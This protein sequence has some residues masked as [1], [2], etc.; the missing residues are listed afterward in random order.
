MKMFDSGPMVL[1]LVHPL[2]RVKRPLLSSKCRSLQS[3][4]LLNR[5]LCSEMAKCLQSSLLSLLSHAMLCI[6][7][8]FLPAIIGK[9][10]KCISADQYHFTEMTEH[11]METRNGSA[12]I[13]FHN[14]L[15]GLILH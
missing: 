8:M 14:C 4:H 15:M 2:G 1:P 9:Y 7:P 10:W 12:G 3:P 6:A 5:L 13:C 11:P